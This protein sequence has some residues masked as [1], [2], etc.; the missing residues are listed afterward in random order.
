M[1]L[2]LEM[3]ERNGMDTAIWIRDCE[4]L[5]HRRNVPIIG[6]T[7]HESEEIKRMC[8]DSGMNIVLTKPIMKADVIA[9]LK[10]YARAS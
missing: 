3:P 9:V 6:L 10:M 1:I 4:K 8:I 2:D 7:G 5:R